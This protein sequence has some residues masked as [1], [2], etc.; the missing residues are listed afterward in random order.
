MVEMEGRAT[1]V[2]GC[3]LAGSGGRGVRSAS[4]ANRRAR[5]RSHEPVIEETSA[6]FFLSSFLTQ[7]Q[8]TTHIRTQPSANIPRARAHHLRHPHTSPANKLTL[9]P[10][11]AASATL[12]RDPRRKPHNTPSATPDRRTGFMYSSLTNALAVD[13]AHVE[14]SFRILRRPRSSQHRNTG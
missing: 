8:S 6:A 3:G 5:A 14:Q 1:R 10:Y 7:Q 2:R 4:A 9:L 12:P 11:Q 13:S